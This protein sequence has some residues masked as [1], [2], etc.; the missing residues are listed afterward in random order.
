MSHF[1]DMGI[2]GTLVFSAILLISS[3]GSREVGQVLTVTPSP[4]IRGAPVSIKIEKLMSSNPITVNVKGTDQLGQAW[5]SSAVFKPVNGG[6][7]VS[8]AT[9]LS[10]S[11]KNAGPEGLFC[12][13]SLDPAAKN[14]TPMVGI[15]KTDITVIQNGVE[16]GKAQLSFTDSSGIVET[17]VS[18]DIFGWL[19]SPAT[20]AAESPAL[21]VLG[22]SEG[23]ARK[24][25]AAGLASTLRV[26][27]F[28]LAYFGLADSTLPYTLQ[29]IPLE[30][31]GKAMDWLNSQ[32]G[33][34]KDSFAVMGISR[35]AE[36]ALLLSSRYPGRIKNVVANVPSSVLWS[37]E[38][39]DPN[40]P[41]W[42][43]GGN[44]IPFIKTVMSPE[45][46]EEYMAVM[47]SGTPF[48][49]R[50]VY[51][52]SLTLLTPDQIAKA[53]IPVEN[54]SGAIMLLSSGLDGVWQSDTF[55]AEIAARLASSGF[56][57]EVTNLSY[58]FSGHLIQ[59]GY[60]PTTLNKYFVP[61]QNIWMD[62]GG[63]P[64]GSAEAN[65]DSWPKMLQF[66]GKVLSN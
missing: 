62:L 24:D 35:G 60:Q 29:D 64:E 58:P 6:V 25:L 26:P 12:A 55:A 54:I 38:G 16:A 7:D 46:Y 39:Q 61:Y 22:G 48:S 59:N 47:K 34:K 36:L 53:S 43:A 52:H 14:V 51:E 31:F 3:C 32:A 19:Y 11:Y 50:K 44:P 63:T 42:T 1:I 65:I 27:V 17:V 33:I 20:A 49:F 8:T 41:S 57:H 66:L 23:G 5:N 10:G 18:T 15:Y 9:P 40:A 2:A 30:Y 28:A 4:I 56:T 45:L 21:I 13:M 37:G